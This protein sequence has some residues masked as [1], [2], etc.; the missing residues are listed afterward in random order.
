[1]APLTHTNVTPT[2][3]MRASAPPTAIGLLPFIFS[4]HSCLYVALPRP[5]SRLTS[6]CR[7]LCRP[8]DTPSAIPVRWQTGITGRDASASAVSPLA[9]PP[10]TQHVSLEWS[11]WHGMTQQH[12]RCT[13]DATLQV[14]VC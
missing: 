5:W 3:K 4:P 6:L 14:S 1:D 8:R 11:G 10:A 13:E 9:T 2:T 7:Q 12:S